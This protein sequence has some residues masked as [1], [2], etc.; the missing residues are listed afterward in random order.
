MLRWGLL[1]KFPVDVD[2]ID[3]G[4]LAEPAD[5]QEIMEGSGCTVLRGLLSPE[6]VQQVRAEFVPSRQSSFIASRLLSP[7]VPPFYVISEALTLCVPIRF[8]HTTLQSL[9]SVMLSDAS[10][11]AGRGGPAAGP[12]DATRRSGSGSGGASG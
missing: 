10:A 3:C 5:A 8:T 6:V 7:S 2:R 11:G 4:D 1:A 9:Q 12:C